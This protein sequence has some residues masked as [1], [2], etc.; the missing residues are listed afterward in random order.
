MTVRNH[1][2]ISDLHP[3]LL[4]SVTRGT[5]SLIGASTDNKKMK[6]NRGRRQYER[7]DLPKGKASVP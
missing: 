1:K 2:R 4:G 5:E 3:I 7:S 6:I